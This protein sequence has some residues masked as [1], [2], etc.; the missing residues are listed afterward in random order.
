MR[1]LNKSLPQS[2]QTPLPPEDLLL[3][4]K[5]AATSV[6]KLYKQA[7]AG[8]SEARQAGYQEAVDD[9]LSFL[10]RKQLGLGDGEGWEVR[11][12]ATERMQ[13]SSHAG[14]NESEDEKEAEAKAPRPSPVTR[15]S[16]PP[17]ASSP[18]HRR[19]SSAS[20]SPPRTAVS[21]SPTRPLGQH[22]NP[23][24]SKPE[25]FTFR[26]NYTLPEDTEMRTQ[27]AHPETSTPPPAVKIEVHPRQTR[28]SPRLSHKHHPRATASRPLGP[29]AGSK[30]RIP[31]GDFFDINGV[32]DI[33]D[34]QT[35]HSK[36]Q[37]G[38]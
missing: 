26:A 17:D 12:W 14:L 21:A 6:T 19:R 30:R 3:A 31:F 4:F 27:D 9:L 36:R 11:R 28:Q 1:S 8:A 10:D 33:K 37:R 35:P 13:G 7:H 29:V 5:D 16:A 23:A 32:L 18:V 38:L 20:R 34:P 25:I 15:S 24:V 22:A 2:S